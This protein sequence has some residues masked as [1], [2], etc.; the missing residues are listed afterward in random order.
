MTAEDTEPG[1]RRLYNVVEEMSIAS[2]LPKVPEVYVIDDLSTGRFDNIA[3][4]IANPR[5]HYTNG[6]ILDE[7]A[8]S[9]LV[10]KVDVVLVGADRVARTVALMP[11]PERAMSM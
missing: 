3:H 9:R 2:G 8:M 11:P 1:R 6:T 4:L 5:F 10:E 7:A